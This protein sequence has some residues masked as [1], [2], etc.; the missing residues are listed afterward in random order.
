MY[1]LPSLTNGISKSQLKIMADMSLKEIFDNGKIIEQ[2]KKIELENLKKAYCDGIVLYW[3]DDN[4]EEL[5]NEKLK[6]IETE[7]LNQTK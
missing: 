2:A 5:W 4:L 6:E 7:L 3:H 1:Q